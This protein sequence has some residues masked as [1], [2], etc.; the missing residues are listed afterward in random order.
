VAFR[1]VLRISSCRRRRTSWA[2]GPWL[3]AREEITG[4]EAGGHGFW[5]EL[6][7]SSL[8]ERCKFRWVTLMPH[9]TPSFPRTRRRLFH[10]Y[11]RA[12]R[13][14][15]S[16]SR[17]ASSLLAPASI[18]VHPCPRYRPHATLR[19]RR[20]PIAPPTVAAPPTAPTSS[21]LFV[22]NPQPQTLI[23]I[24]GRRHHHQY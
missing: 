20:R 22:R 1:E 14:L 21:I 15:P 10:R 4:G 13:D 6:V 5:L 19:S 8:C 11:H 24:V 18:P 23:S 9:A 2:C 17:L 3:V 12:T 7:N 16:S